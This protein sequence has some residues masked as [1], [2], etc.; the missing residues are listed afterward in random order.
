VETVGFSIKRKSNV[1]EKHQFYNT[2]TAINLRLIT[3]ARSKEFVHK[4][5][6]V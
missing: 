3:K 2:L 4:H 5:E 6:L 1:D